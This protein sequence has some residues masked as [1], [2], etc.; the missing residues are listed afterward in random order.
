MVDS[1][2]AQW[3]VS[4]L[5]RIWASSLRVE[6]LAEGMKMVWVVDHWQE[7]EGVWMDLRKELEAN[8]NEIGREVDLPSLLRR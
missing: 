2:P 4:P 3:S 6:S 8:R 5:H 1:N 7:Q